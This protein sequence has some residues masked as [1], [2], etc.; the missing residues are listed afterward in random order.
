LKIKIF[1]ENPF[2]PQLKT[3]SLSGKEKDCWAFWVDYHYRIKFVFLNNAET[4]FLD[5][6][7]HDIYI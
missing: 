4:L 6:G 7:L 5:V 1:R 2:N 3:H